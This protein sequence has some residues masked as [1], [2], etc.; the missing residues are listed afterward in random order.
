ML[1]ENIPDCPERDEPAHQHMDFLFLA[2][3]ID[4]AQDLVLAE[5]EG[6]DIKWFTKADIEALDQ[7]SEI[8]G[9]VKAY[10]LQI[11]E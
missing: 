10:I 9:N 5:E 1:L 4:E 3:P 11:L 8:F 2:R 6:E 7:E